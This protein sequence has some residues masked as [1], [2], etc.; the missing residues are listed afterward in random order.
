MTNDKMSNDEGMTKSEERA[1]RFFGPFGHS[2]LIR[3]LQL[4]LDVAR[5]HGTGVN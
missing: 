3:H 2:D 4:H 1:P 5:H